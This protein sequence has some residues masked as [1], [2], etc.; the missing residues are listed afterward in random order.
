MCMSLSI[1][2]IEAQK[3]EEMEQQFMGGG[4]DNEMFDGDDHFSSDEE[5]VDTDTLPSR[6]VSDPTPTPRQR[7]LSGV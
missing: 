7:V 5:D 3:M 6:P 4:V 2:E 1:D